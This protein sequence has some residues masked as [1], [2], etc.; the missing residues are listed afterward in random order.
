MKKKQG[1][2][3]TFTKAKDITYKVEKCHTGTI[4]VFSDPVS[5]IKFMGG[6]RSRGVI[7]YPNCILLDVGIAYTQEITTHPKNLMPELNKYDQPVVSIKISDFDAPGLDLY[8][9]Q[10]LLSGL[11]R[12]KKDVIVACVGGHGRTGLTLSI[13]SVLTGACPNNEDPV[14]FVRKRYCEKA[15]ESYSQICYISKITGKEVK[16]VPI[17]R[18]SQYGYHYSSGMY[19]SRFEDMF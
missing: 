7:L 1:R 13:L 16:E 5:G 18:I 8:F 6:G 3:N 10:D 4:T 15:V 12:I 19:G 9:W 11:R 14:A 17:S 2:S